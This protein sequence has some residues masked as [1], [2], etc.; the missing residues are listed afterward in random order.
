[1]MKATRKIAHLD[2]DHVSPSVNGALDDP[3]VVVY[4]EDGRSQQVSRVAHANLEAGAK[5]NRQGEHQ[6]QHID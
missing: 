2:T 5:Q 3:L 6:R 4:S 1:M